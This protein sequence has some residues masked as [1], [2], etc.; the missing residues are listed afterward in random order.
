MG[1]VVSHILTAGLDSKYDY[2]TTK[3]CKYQVQFT[4][5][6]IEKHIDMVVAHQLC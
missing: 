6:W 2:N 4:W 5:D 3:F 1:P